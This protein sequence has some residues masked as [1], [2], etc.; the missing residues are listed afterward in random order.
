MVL[1][2]AITFSCHLYLCNRFQYRESKP[3]DRDGPST[4]RRRGVPE[5][6]KWSKGNALPDVGDDNS[7]EGDG[8]RRDGRDTDRDRPRNAEGRRP[9]TDRRD[10]DDDDGAERDRQK[11]QLMAKLRSMGNGGQGREPQQSNRGGGRAG[12]EKR[13]D[14]DDGRYDNSNYGNEY[15]PNSQRRYDDNYD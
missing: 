14:D 1:C 7:Y 5:E 13:Y 6:T 2:Y 3:T 9:A 12:D 8:G 10:Q 11:E 15:A 4:N